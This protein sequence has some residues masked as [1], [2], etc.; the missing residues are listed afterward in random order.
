MINENKFIS[1]LID[2]YIFTRDLEKSIDDNYAH[3]RATSLASGVKEIILDPTIWVN[4]SLPTDDLVQKMTDDVYKAGYAKVKNYKKWVLGYGL[5]MLWGIFD[6]FLNTLVSEILDSNPNLTLW[7]TK[8]EIIRRF[9]EGTFK[10]K[11]NTFKTRLN[12]TEQEFF[13]FSIFI[14][15]IQKKFKDINFEE[16]NKIYKKRNIAAHSDNY[17]IYTIGE[18]DYIRELFEKLIWNLSIKT[19]RKWGIKSE[20]IELI[21]SQGKSA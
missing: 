5:V 10:D 18:L 6:D 2:I 9:Q 16:M 14:I 15:S 13:D 20:L 8:E 19:R 7:S 21:K 17:V 12:L 4:N 3:Y 11:F 1:K